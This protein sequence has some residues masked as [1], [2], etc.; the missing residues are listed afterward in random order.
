MVREAG[1]CLQNPG[2]IVFSVIWWGFF[3]CRIFIPFQ[4][5]IPPAFISQPVD[6][7]PYADACQPFGKISDLFLLPELPVLEQSVVHYFLGVTSAARDPQTDIVQ[8]AAV[9][10][11]HF[12]YVNSVFHQVSFS[13]L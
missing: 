8:S 9:G 12:F 11:V 6:G 4:K 5:F 2:S 7:L 13:P 3:Q 10:V 1:Q